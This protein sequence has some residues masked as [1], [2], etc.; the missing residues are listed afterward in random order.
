[1]PGVPIYVD[2][3][4]QLL[5]EFFRIE[6]A[7]GDRPHGGFLTVQD[8]NRLL[9]RAGLSVVA[10][11]PDHDEIAKWYSCYHLVGLA[12]VAPKG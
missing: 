2:Y 5:D 7:G 4:F 8:W 12:A 11:L 10:M 9:T 3:P 6:D 1:V